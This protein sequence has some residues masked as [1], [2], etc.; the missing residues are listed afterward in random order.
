MGQYWHSYILY[1]E[2]LKMKL[3]EYLHNKMGPPHAITWRS[4]RVEQIEEWIVEW[5]RSE[6]TEVGCDGA[7]AEP[8]MPPSWLAVWR[9]NEKSK[10]E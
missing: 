1:G 4:R 3:S 6:F 10:S 7:L 5:Y 8:R 9:R 2:D